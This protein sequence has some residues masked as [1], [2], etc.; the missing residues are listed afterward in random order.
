MS[1]LSLEFLLLAAC[2]V[3]LYYLLP[4]RIRWAVLLVASAVYV[5]LSGWHSAAHLTVVALLMWG[6][7]L[8]LERKR[9]RLLLALLVGLDMSAMLLLKYAPIAQELLVPVGLSYFTFQSAGYLVDVYRGKAQAQKN[10]LRAWLFVGYFPQLAQ[11]PIS[12][13]KELGPQLMTGHRLEPEQFVS[14]FTLLLWG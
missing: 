1:I 2:T 4:L 12:S 11:G 6:G 3:L 13:W 9:S 5:G 10:P 7:G 14:G 8:L